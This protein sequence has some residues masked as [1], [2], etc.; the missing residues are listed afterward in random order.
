MQ[1]DA[2]QIHSGL[3]AKKKERH[4]LARLITRSMGGHENE[5]NGRVAEAVNHLED[6]DGIRT[7]S[8]DLAKELNTTPKKWFQRTNFWIKGT[9]ITMIIILLFALTWVIMNISYSKNLGIYTPGMGTSSRLIQDLNISIKSKRKKLAETDR[10]LIN[11]NTFH[12][13]TGGYP[14]EE[15]MSEEFIK[16]NAAEYVFQNESHYMIPGNGKE[17]L[18]I[19]ATIDPD[20]PWY[21]YQSIA[22]LAENSGIK[23]AK[24]SRSVSTATSVSYDQSMV[25]EAWILLE[26]A[27]KMG[28][29]IQ[30][31]DSLQ[32]EKQII[33]SN[34]LSHDYHGF[35][36]Y[37]GFNASYVMNDTMGYMKVHDI[38]NA[39][40]ESL[41]VRGTKAEVSKW[42][43]IYQRYLSSILNAQNT[44]I[45]YL[46]V[47]AQLQDYEAMVEGALK[48]LELDSEIKKAQLLTQ[49]LEADKNHRNELQVKWSSIRPEN[50]E[51][52]VLSLLNTDA[53]LS[54]ELPEMDAHIYNRNAEHA[55]ATKYLCIVFT[56]LL[57]L[58]FIYLSGYGLMKG[59]SGRFL[60]RQISEKLNANDWL[61]I[62][63]TGTVLPIGLYYLTNHSEWFGARRWGIGAGSGLPIIFQFISLFLLQLTLSYCLI[64]WRLFVSS[65]GIV[66]AVHK[67]AWSPA[68]AAFIL[69]MLSGLVGKDGMEMNWIGYV[70]L[71]CIA[72]IIL[73]LF[74]RSLRG[75]TK[76]QNALA[77]AGIN[78]CMI[79]IVSLGI[80][81]AI[82]MA[83]YYHAE[84]K[85]WIL[86]DPEFTFDPNVFG[87]TTQ[88][89]KSAMYL[90]KQLQETLKILK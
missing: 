11:D 2:V 72:Y 53:T 38:F 18:E 71:A 47:S 64:R 76:H 45:G 44:F 24:S 66:K 15:P 41:A 56:V 61:I 37:M 87:T 79:L 57:F 43:N 33:M 68:I 5:M 25:Q 85:K 86:S 8:E 31:R 83:P 12:P 65:Q 34:T 90:R 75:F 22:H 19:G 51:Y 69:M 88:E 52:G 23:P 10:W 58:V 55:I 59:R 14:F 42:L 30:H 49:K 3:D 21:L 13:L 73:S 84:E 39:K 4:E 82:I 77:V 27:D 74:Y 20:N 35:I 17:L 28:E 29:L 9:V 6:C 54:N 60:G 80:I 67:S 26:K 1:D 63:L 16:Q 78:R 50:H 36:A 48:R 81:S 40:F 7:W 70:C 46:I 89:Y 32:W 62:L